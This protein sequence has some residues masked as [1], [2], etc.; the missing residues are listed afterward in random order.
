MGTETTEGLS[1]AS[2]VG[3]GERLPGLWL[4]LLAQLTSAIPDWS[5]MKGVSSALAGT[6]DV[7]SIAPVSA[8]GPVKDI[9]HGWA[10]AEGLG[11]VVFCPHAP[12][13]LHIVAVSDARPEVFELDVNS[14]KIFFGSTLFRP[15]DVAGLAVMDPL[16]FRRLRP[17][18]EGVL[19]L[20]QNGST[21]T[22]KPI[23]EGLEAKKVTELLESDPEGAHLFARQFR[24]GTS[25]MVKAVD[26][27]IA[28]KWDRP[29]LAFAKLTCVA[30]APR[31]PDAVVA[32]VRFRWQRNHCPVLR[33]VVSGHRRVDSPSTWL[34]EVAQ[35]HEV[36]F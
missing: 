26:A 21:R 36:R 4:S 17:G 28:G 19:K 24:S 12:Y 13:L 33:T 2:P 7:D 32:R 25:T 11:P 3:L 29:S 1:S 16:G 5:A 14:R 9:F 20:I 30:R 10:N 18:A 22:A 15:P 34:R 6:G 23:R 27:V 35:Y 31:E 8:W